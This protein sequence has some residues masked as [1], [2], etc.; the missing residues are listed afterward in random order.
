[1][2]R[3]LH[4]DFETRSGADLKAV[5]SDNYSLHPSTDFLCLAFSFD[6]DPVDLMTR[7]NRLQK[8]K[9]ILSHIKSGGKVIGHNVGG[10]E[11]LIWNNVMGPKY[12]WPELKIE[13]CEDTMPMAYA[14]SLPGSLEEAALA[15]GIKYQKDMKGH[16]IMLQLSQPRKINP[17][18]SFTWWE[19]TE[20]PEKFETLYQYCKTDVEVERELHKRLLKLTPQEQKLW[21]L[22][23]K[24]NRRGV[25][26]DMPAAKKAIE[27][28][29]LHKEN[30]NNKMRR[31]T[32]NEVATCNAVAQLSDWLKDWG[33][34]VPSVAKAELL[35][36][37]NEEALP[38]ECREAMLIRQEAAK[39]SNA[40]YTA[41]ISG[42]GPDDR[43]RGL[44]Q[45][46]GA[47][48]GRWAGRR[49]QLQNLPRP[50]LEPDEI[51]QVFDILK[52]KSAKECIDLIDIFYG[53]PI[54]TMSDCI[55]GTLKSKPGHDLIGCDFNAV[56]AR[57]LAWLAGE[58]RV[59]EIF[60]THG[61]IYEHAAAGIY[62]V[63]MSE[64]TKSDPRRQ[65]GKVAIL[66]LGY[67]G[68]VGAF[69]QMAKAYNVKVT[70]AEAEIIKLGWRDSNPNIV[71]YWWDLE[72]AAI[73][74][75]Q[76]P[77]YKF[78][79]GTNASTFLV[80]GS[81]LWCRLPSGR[82]LCYPYPKIEMIDTPW[83]VSKEALTYM[84]LDT[85]TKKWSRLK[86]YGGSIC[87]NITQAVARDLLAEALPRLEEN[88]Y[89]VVMHVHDE[90]VTEVPKGWG[91]VDEVSRIMC[92]LPPWAKG[93]PLAAGGW[94][95]ERF[96]K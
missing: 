75:V 44:F 53:P 5:G 55:R 19:E 36:L 31:L 43:I 77:G 51:N 65:I 49:V 68:G 63:S 6:K 85:Y 83:G 46:C 96:Q 14:M 22:D 8:E 71:K 12:A 41:M 28:V 45:Y 7:S 1:L 50:R 10:F 58:D 73:K 82:A 29:E 94:R 17:D 3:E 4:L 78:S 35:E 89:P 67:Q 90:A 61:K 93:L 40:K 59:L 64:I 76:M 66:A 95:K 87:E 37:L 21:Q 52:T 16:R 26:I 25:M 2:G 92:Q 84:G 23:W 62:K 60:K 70:D 20:V 39:S 80:N 18:G 74:A 48:T 42:A 30:L 13:Q 81:F 15:A 91:S 24:I 38:P 54:T 86:T 11:I 57:V 33:L 27:I 72:S 9:L 79:A 56:E 32:N 88:N 47:G 34:N 69:Q